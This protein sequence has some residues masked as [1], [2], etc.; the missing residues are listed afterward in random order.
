MLIVVCSPG[1]LRY[2]VLSLIGHRIGIGRGREREREHIEDSGGRKRTRSEEKE[3][4]EINWEGV[5]TR[6]YYIH[7]MTIS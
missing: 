7:S 5:V 2:V 4:K 3:T 1:C 6:A